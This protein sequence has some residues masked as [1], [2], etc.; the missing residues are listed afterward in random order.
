MIQTG[1]H[2]VH[3]KLSLPFV[4]NELPLEVWQ[5]LEVLLLL[6]HPHNLEDVHH[7]N[8]NILDHKSFK[9]KTFSYNRIEQMTLLT[10]KKLYLQLSREKALKLLLQAECERKPAHV[11]SLTTLPEVNHTL[12][13]L[14]RLL[15]LVL[16]F[17]FITLL[18]FFILLI[19]DRHPVPAK[20]HTNKVSQLLFFKQM[21]ETAYR[22][23]LTYRTDI[24]GKY[25]RVCL[26]R[27][28]APWLQV[29]VLNN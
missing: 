14:F 16:S 23:L 1:L 25:C 24:L 10:V 26:G 28:L 13:V 21:K 29:N 9:K 27:K 8:G 18:F 22:T 5:E 6:G 12:E 15:V 2:I 3:L 11:G 17:S 20:Q 19:L 7:E 4:D